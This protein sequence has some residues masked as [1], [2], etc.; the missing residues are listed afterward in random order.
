MHANKTRFSTWFWSGEEPEWIVVITVLIALMLG[1]VIM[2][3][4]TGQ[5]AVATLDRLSIKYPATWAVADDDTTG[6]SGAQ[7]MASNASVMVEVFRKLDPANPVLMD[8]LVAL[9]SFQQAQKLTLYRVLSTQAVTV[10]GKSGVMI[11]YA[12]VMDPAQSAYQSTLPRVMKGADYLVP[13]QGQVYLVTLEAQSNA[14]QPA[15]FES[16]IQSVRWN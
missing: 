2:L 1:G 4:A 16:I 9:R 8:D 13:Y 14:W 6:L 15:L 7:D 10:G 12:Y 5:M 3:A 11:N